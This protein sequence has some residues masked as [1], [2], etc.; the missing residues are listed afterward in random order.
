V[1]TLLPAIEPGQGRALQ[2]PLPI[3]GDPLRFIA[4]ARRPSSE[5]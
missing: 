5:A 3:V 1:F 2:K 4:P